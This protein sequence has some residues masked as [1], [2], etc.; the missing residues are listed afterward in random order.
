MMVPASGRS[1]APIKCRMV[2][3]PE[4]EAPVSAANARGSIVR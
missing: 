1:I 4:P 3:L 2:D